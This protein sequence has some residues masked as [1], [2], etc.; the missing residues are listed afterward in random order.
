MEENYKERYEALLAGVNPEMLDDAITLANTR[1][2]E[3]IPFADAIGSVVE[4]YPQFGVN[5]PAPEKP[6]E[7]ITTGIHTGGRMNPL[8]GVEA[9]FLS[10]NPGIKI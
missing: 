3:E 7:T 2:T 10:R 5:K 9:E 6:M 8:S 1:V 4:K